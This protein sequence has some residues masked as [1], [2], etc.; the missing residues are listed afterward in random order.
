MQLYYFTVFLISPYFF[1]KKSHPQNSFVTPNG[2]D[3]VSPRQPLENKARKTI[4][5]K[6]TPKT[7]NIKLTLQPSNHTYICQK[8]KFNE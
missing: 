8:T 6:N 5:I 7:I 1:K 3:G 4:E 2:R